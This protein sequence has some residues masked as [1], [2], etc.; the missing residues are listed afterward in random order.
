MVESKVEVRWALIVLMIFPILLLSPWS[1][2]WFIPP[3][4][5]RDLELVRESKHSVDLLKVSIRTF[6][7][8][9]LGILYIHLYLSGSGYGLDRLVY[10][11]FS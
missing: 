7:K 3:V 11:P 8:D 10:L 2:G 4:G 9:G 6:T 1:W 5:G